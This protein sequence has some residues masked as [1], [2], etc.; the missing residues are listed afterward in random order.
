M[1]ASMRSNW[2]LA[3]II[4]A[5]P[6]CSGSDTMPYPEATTTYTCRGWFLVFCTAVPRTVQ[7]RQELTSQ[8]TAPQS[9]QSVSRLKEISAR[10]DPL[11]IT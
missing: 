3:R 9:V 7:V 1:I 10:E 11:Y 6:A 2:R 5:P 8:W 4:T